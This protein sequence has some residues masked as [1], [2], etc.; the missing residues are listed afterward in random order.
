[1]E[2]AAPVSSSIINF[3]PLTKTG[4]LK[5]SDAQL[6][7]WYSRYSLPLLPSVSDVGDLAASC[8]RCVLRCLFRPGLP[9]LVQLSLRVVF[10]TGLRLRTTYRRY[11]TFIPAVITSRIFKFAVGGYVCMRCNRSDSMDSLRLGLGLVG[12]RTCGWQVQHP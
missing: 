12:W 8:T 9:Y 3:L 11:V 6:V 10:G 7:I 2:T 1:M 4:T 5:G